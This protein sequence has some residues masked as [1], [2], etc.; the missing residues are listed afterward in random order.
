MRVVHAYNKREQGI[1]GDLEKS[2]QQLV[3]EF[4]FVSRRNY[5]S[6]GDF[7]EARQKLR[8]HATYQAG[9]CVQALRN[10]KWERATIVDVD[11]SRKPVVYEAVLDDAGRGK[12]IQVTAE[13]LRKLKAQSQRLAEAESAYRCVGGGCV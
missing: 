13:E 1:D 3:D 6:D 5:E 2:R 12:T 10:E 11:H 9:E 8:E 7:R 4:G